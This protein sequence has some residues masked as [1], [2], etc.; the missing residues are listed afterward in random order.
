MDPIPSFF[1]PFIEQRHL[2]SRII[3]SRHTISREL[4]THLDEP[5]IFPS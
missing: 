4:N 1:L 2:I 3:A 5:N